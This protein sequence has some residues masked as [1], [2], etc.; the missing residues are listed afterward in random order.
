M[1]C[2]TK[3]ISEKSAIRHTYEDWGLIQ[4]D[5]AIVS[6]PKVQ[7][8]YI[9][10]KGMDGVLDY[11]TALDGNVHYEARDFK[12]TLLK[13]SDGSDLKSLFTSMMN[14]MHG[15]RMKVICDDDPNYYWEGR[16]EVGD[17][18]WNDKG[19]WKID[20]K[21]I[22]DPYKYYLTSSMED[23]MWDPF[24]FET[25]IAW[26][27]ANLTVDEEM[28]LVIVTSNM[29]T[30]PIFRLSAPMKMTVNGEMEYNLPKGDST[31]PGM[32]LTDSDTTL[33]F[34]GSGTVTV[35]FRGGS[36]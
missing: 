27:Y 31:I 18:S 22:V 21:G 32:V 34:Y 7:T 25:D 26:D 14:F 9:S 1:I 2:G 24:V 11:T 13:I 8:N 35:G 16:F 12:V 29:P 10:V 6:A 30:T 28:E 3:F 17:P 15:R 36:L 4:T 33:V 23:W 5:P 20:I 19:Y